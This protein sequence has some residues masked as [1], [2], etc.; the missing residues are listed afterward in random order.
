M[1]SRENHRGFITGFPVENW[2]TYPQ[3][4]GTYPQFSWGYPQFSDF[5]GEIPTNS[6]VEK[7]TFYPQLSRGYPQAEAALSTV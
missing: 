6:E 4:K 5:G 7:L 1:S 2:H 3:A